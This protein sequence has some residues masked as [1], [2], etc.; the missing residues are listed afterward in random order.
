MGTSVEFGGGQGGGVGMAVV[1]MVLES[2]NVATSM[3]WAF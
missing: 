1:K 2:E 3:R